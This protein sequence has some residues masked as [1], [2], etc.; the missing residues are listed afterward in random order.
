MTKNDIAQI[1]DNAITAVG[2]HLIAI[3]KDIW[4]HPE[5]GYREERTS[6]LLAAEFVPRQTIQYHSNPSLCPNQ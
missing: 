1:S 6:A 5:T 2:D 3:S 4:Q